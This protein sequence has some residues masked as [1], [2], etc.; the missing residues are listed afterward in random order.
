MGAVSTIGNRRWRNAASLAGYCAALAGGR[1]PPRELEELPPE[2]RET[3]RLMLGLRL[4]EPL[5]IAGAAGMLDLHELAR[6]E[7]LGLAGGGA[8]RSRSPPAGASSA[9]ASPR[10]CS[11]EPA[12]RRR[13][14]PRE[15][16]QSPT[17][18]RG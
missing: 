9:T 2:V 10:R 11:P 12:A 6:L 7:R 17:M 3:E 4:D 8:R 14:G 1:R 15:R 13:T 18:S 5:S 16:A